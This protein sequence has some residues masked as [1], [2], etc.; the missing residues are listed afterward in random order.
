MQ[1][2]YP[3][4]SPIPMIKKTRNVTSYN[5]R[6]GLTKL[7]KGKRPDWLD[8]GFESRKIQLEIKVNKGEN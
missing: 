1:G 3:G 6:K 7:G 4:A 2:S 8:I 5:R